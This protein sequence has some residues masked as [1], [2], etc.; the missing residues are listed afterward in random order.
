MVQNCIKRVKDQDDWCQHLC[1]IP[2]NSDENV[3][4][5]IDNPATHSENHETSDQGNFFDDEGKIFTLLV[6][7]VSF[8]KYSFCDFIIKSKFKCIQYT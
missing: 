6:K 4:Y 8:C 5:E 1:K 3:E 2:V 7:A